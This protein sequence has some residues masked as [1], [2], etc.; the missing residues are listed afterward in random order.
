MSEGARW[1]I[2][3]ILAGA[4]IIDVAWGWFRGGKS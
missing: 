4:L 1:L 2:I 3:E